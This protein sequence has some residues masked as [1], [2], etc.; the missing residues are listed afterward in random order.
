MFGLGFWELLLILVIVLILFG[1]KRLP[2]LGSSLGEGI[3]NFTKSVREEESP[4]EKKNQ[5]GEE[6]GDSS[7]LPGKDD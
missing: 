4:P 7:K 6:T 5:T 1:V 2:Q 3:R